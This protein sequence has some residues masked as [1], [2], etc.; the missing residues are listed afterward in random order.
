[1]FANLLPVW[2]K[3]ILNKQILTKTKKEKNYERERD[4]LRLLP[5]HITLAIWSDIHWPNQWHLLNVS[6][7]L[8]SMVGLHK[9]E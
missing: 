7:L 2:G 8:G 9:Y 4:L 3:V 1:M 6:S 5:H